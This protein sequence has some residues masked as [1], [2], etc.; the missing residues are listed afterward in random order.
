MTLN[1]Q[2]TDAELQAM[3]AMV[4]HPE[5]VRSEIG[6]DRQMAATSARRREAK[7]RKRLESPPERP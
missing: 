3:L 4:F 1:P 6:I 7:S 2:R 5:R